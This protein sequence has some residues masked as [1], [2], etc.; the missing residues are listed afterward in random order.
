MIK[1]ITQISKRL[2][3]KKGNSKMSD[4]V[5]LYT[6]PL[7]NLFHSDSV[8]PCCDIQNVALAEIGD[9]HFAL[10]YFQPSA[11]PFSSFLNV[12]LHKISMHFHHR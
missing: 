2:I 1:P 10:P 8:N 12:Q 6:Q 3:R 4:K 5:F 11:I 7:L 9:A